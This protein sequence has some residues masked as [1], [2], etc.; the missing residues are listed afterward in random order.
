MKVR[1]ILILVISVVLLA[2]AGLL[3][4]NT[5][6]SVS[7]IDVS[8]FVSSDKAQEDSLKIRQSL[9]T[10]YK[11]KNLLFVSQDDVRA[12]MD[13]YPYMKVVSVEKAYPAT[14][15]LSLEER[16]ERYAV[17]V[18]EEGNAVY[19]MT[20]EEGNVLAERSVNENNVD[21]NPNFLIRGLT[22]GAAF[23]SDKN[24]RTVL[25]V[26]AAMDEAVGG[27]RTCLVGLEVFSPTSNEA[28]AKFIVTTSEGVTICIVHP[29]SLPREKAEKAM[30]EYRKLDDGQKGRG[31]LIV[32]DDEREEG[33]ISWNYTESV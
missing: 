33:K 32:T 10:E 3:G 28:D 25:T 17:C 20:D 29:Q 11:G 24:W 27:V 31:Y 19:Y 7:F 21:N 9:E 4:V 26:C 14:L 13:G 6:F 23:S 8:F 16:S 12:F 18:V 22:G 2:A 15:K 30:E 1:K 5:V